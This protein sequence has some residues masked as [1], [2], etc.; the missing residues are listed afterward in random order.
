MDP[1]RYQQDCFSHISSVDGGVVYDTG[2]TTVEP[3]EGDHAGQ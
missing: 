3:D 2:N 1:Q